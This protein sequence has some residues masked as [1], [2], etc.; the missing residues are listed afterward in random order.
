MDVQPHTKRR[1]WRLLPRRIGRRAETEARAEIELGL[2]LAEEI[3]DPVIESA[4]LG[5]AG[6]VACLRGEHDRGAALARL[7]LEK[8]RELGE[9]IWIWAACI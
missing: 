1:R 6:V 8:A 9:P 4:G 5:Y 3:A 7:G 2:T